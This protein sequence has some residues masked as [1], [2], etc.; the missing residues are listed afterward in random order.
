MN[1]KEKVDLLKQEIA[2]FNDKAD[3]FYRI[4]IDDYLKEFHL[5][6][7][8]KTISGHNAFIYNEAKRLKKKFI[9]LANEL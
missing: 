3:G 6:K 7:N 8:R 1:W 5:I 9:T 4:E 2:I